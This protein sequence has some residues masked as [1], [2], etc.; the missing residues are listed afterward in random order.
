MPSNASEIIA[1]ARDFQP[2]QTFLVFVA[3][4]VL[5]FI[6]HVLNISQRRWKLR[7]MKHKPF[8]QLVKN[9]GWRKASRF[10]F[11]AA[12]QDAFGRSLEPVEFAFMQTRSRP[13]A[14]LK[15]RFAGASFVDF[16][17]EQMR[18]EWR[19][20]TQRDPATLA[21]WANFWTFAGIFLVSLAI[22]LS[23]QGLQSLSPTFVF[24]ILLSAMA[25]AFG[26]LVGNAL[27]AASRLLRLQELYPEA[28]DIPKELTPRRRVVPKKKK[29]ANPEDPA[30]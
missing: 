8:R 9:D 1:T 20:K 16:N 24:P 17:V 11:H 21:K 26:F 14:L 4:G 15:D 12:M 5:A 2:L 23:W 13:L 18:Y 30:T 7:A 10:D 29:P 27:E 25:G 19:G 3:S 22:T 28:A 6:L